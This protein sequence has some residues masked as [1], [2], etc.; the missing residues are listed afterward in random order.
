MSEVLYPWLQPA[1]A[2]IRRQQ[3]AGRLP[4]AYLLSGQSGVGKSAFARF[5]AR[6]LLCARPSDEGWCGECDSCLLWAAGTHP[7]SLSLSPPDGKQIITV[8]QVRDT[9][10]ELELTPQCGSRKVAVIDPAD[11]MN[12]NAANGL[13]KT[14]EE[15]AASDLLILVSS[16]PGFMPATI[17]SRC[18][19]VSL[20]QSPAQAAMTRDWLAAQLPDQVASLDSLMALVPGQPLR[21]FE[22][23]DKDYLAL[24]QG[25]F[26]DM[27]DVIAGRKPLGKTASQYGKTPTRTLLTLMLHWFACALKLASGVAPPALPE[28]ERKRLEPFAKALGAEKI[29]RIYNKLQQLY[30][31]DSASF[32]TETVLEGIFADMRL[33]HINRE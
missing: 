33:I 25:F 22:L 13:L 11:A 19:V 18:Q 26:D 8:D 20:V 21:V 23:A 4:H 31:I 28:A 5:L 30:A 1:W 29:I 6:S 32:K 15:P 7:D 3:E 14:L 17:R 10:N 12:T 24:R 27:L 2:R 9:I 16:S